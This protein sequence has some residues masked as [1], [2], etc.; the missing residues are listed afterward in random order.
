MEL[1]VNE[2][3]YSIQGE[4]C[5]AGFTSLFVRLSG[6]N[7]DCPYCDTKYA[8][9]DGVSC[10]I[11]KILRIAETQKPFNHV[12]VTGGEPLI[13]SNTQ[14]L[15]NSLIENNYDVQ[16]ETNGSIS[17]RNINPKARKIADV[18]TPSSGES[19]SFQMENLKYLSENDELKFLVSDKNDF[20]FSFNFIKENMNKIKAVINFSPV[21][22]DITPAELSSLIIGNRLNARL[23]LQLH[24]LIWQEVPENKIVRNLLT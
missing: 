11:N 22:G 13:Q 2:I 20:D 21:F 19:E 1:L 23:N 10:S 18:K 7:L 16:I 14:V 3:F 6:C 12:T 17:L 24:K 8:R 9:E 4:T 15:I 5:T